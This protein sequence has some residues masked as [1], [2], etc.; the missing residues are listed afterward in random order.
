[1]MMILSLHFI[2]QSISTTDASGSSTDKT[3]TPES[4]NE[5][6]PATKKAK[7]ALVKPAKSKRG[8]ITEGI[9]RSGQSI[10]PRQFIAAVRNLNS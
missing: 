10:R 5:A 4:S 2:L 9:K 8:L 1:M 7:K 3:L 6:E